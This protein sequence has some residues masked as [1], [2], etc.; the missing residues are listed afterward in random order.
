MAPNAT[1]TDV[2]STGNDTWGPDCF[3]CTAYLSDMLTWDNYSGV[4]IL[5]AMLIGGLFVLVVIGMIAKRCYEGLT[6]RGYSQVD[7]LINGM[8]DADDIDDDEEWL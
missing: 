1:S 4:A 5:A 2:S 6:H 8:Y 7:Y 3:L